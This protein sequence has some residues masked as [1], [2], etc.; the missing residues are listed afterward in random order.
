MKAMGVF[1]GGIAHDFNNILTVI[2]GY[3]RLLE[4]RI[5]KSDPG[6]NYLHQI[7][8]ASNRAKDLIRQ[9]Q[10]FSHNSDHNF[11]P[12]DICSVLQDNIKLLSSLI[13]TS[14]EIKTNFDPDCG[15]V[16]TEPSQILQVIINLCINAVQ[17]MDEKGTLSICLKKIEFDE[18]EAINYRDIASG[19]Y[20][21]LSVT[22][23]GVGIDKSV[24]EHIFDPFVTTK[25]V[26]SGTGM[27]LSVVYG[28]VERHKG[29]I[30]FISVPGEGT[31][32]NVFLPLC[33][34][35][36]PLIKHDEQDV[37]GGNQSI[38]FIDDEK[39]LLEMSEIYFQS[40]GYK[41][42]AF[43]SSLEAYEEFVNHPYYYDLVITD[44]TMPHLNGDKLAK[45]ILKI[46][47][48]MP[49]IL[50]SGYSNKITKE[51]AMSIGI[52]KML[53]KPVQL[54]EFTEVVQKVLEKETNPG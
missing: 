20:I 30:D 52:R 4:E 5:S 54:D 1:A 40:L 8:D 33:E 12:Y 32:F 53:L 3:S 44:Q 7:N 37:K 41:V 39:M 51:V 42:S 13:P 9:I 17:A 34:K 27:G 26:G 35:Q 2:L 43:S 29:V 46:R 23:T 14:V 21:Q 25:G 38:L 16:L 15:N 11:Q 36:Q 47:P 28:I 18:C 49:I 22:D 24:I 45:K 50:C 48:D 31:T 10:A 19:S 6:V